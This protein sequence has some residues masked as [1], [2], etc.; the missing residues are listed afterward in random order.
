M[1]DSTQARTVRDDDNAV[2]GDAA[3]TTPFLLRAPLRSLHT[4]GCERGCR[5]VAPPPWPR[6]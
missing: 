6:A 3:V 5:P 4:Q 1:N 2:V